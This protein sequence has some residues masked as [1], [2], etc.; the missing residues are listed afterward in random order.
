MCGSV[1][2]LDRNEVFNYAI[3]HL[4]IDGLY[5]EFGVKTGKTIKIL[6]QKLRNKT[7]YGF[8]SFAGLPSDW[9]GNRKLQGQLDAKGK[10]PKIAKN[11]RLI[12]GWFKD[13]LPNFSKDH[14]ENIAL[15]HID[16]DIYSSTKDIFDGLGEKITKGTVLIFDEYFNYPNWQAHEFKAFAEFTKKHRLKYKY[17]CYAHTQVVV[18]IL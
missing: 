16:C 2:C 1:M 7:I 17:L 11:I 15:I 12:Q 13:T 5:L 8:D 18:V 3:K 14:K 4:T 6:G 10:L 9:T